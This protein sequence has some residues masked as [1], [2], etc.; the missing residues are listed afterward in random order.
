MARNQDKTTTEE[1]TFNAVSKEFIKYGGEHLKP[2]DTFHVKESDVKELGDFAK[3][4]IPKE[5][6]TPPVDPPDGQSQQPGGNGGQ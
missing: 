6:A 4:E 3:I 1:K 5:T 2:G